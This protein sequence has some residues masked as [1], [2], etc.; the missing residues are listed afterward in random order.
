MAKEKGILVTGRVI[1]V[2]PNAMFKVELDETK[3]VVLGY[4]SGK[5]KKFKI[6]VLLGDNVD[7]ELSPYDLSKGRI[8]HR[9]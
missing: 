3:H 4:L 8:T 7:I 5:I 1:D 9:N 6:K 2:L